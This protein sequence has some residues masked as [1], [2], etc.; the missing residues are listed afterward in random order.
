MKIFDSLAKTFSASK[1]P[2]VSAL[3]RAEI[4]AAKALE[5]AR[6]EVTRLQ[7]ALPAALVQGDAARQKARA[8]LRAAEDDAADAE[9]ALSIV[10]ERLTEARHEADQAARRTAYAAAQAV[11]DEAVVRL[12]SRYP[13]IVAELRGLIEATARADAEVEEAN[14]ALPAGAA[15]L[16]RVEDEVRDVPSLPRRVLAERQV[17]LWAPAGTARPAADQGGIRDEGGGRGR[18]VVVAHGGLSNVTQHF[19]LLSFTERKVAPG[20]NAAFA[21]RLHGLDLPALRADDAPAWSPLPPDSSPNAILAHL[22]ALAT[23]AGAPP[24]PEPERI[25]IEHEL[26]VP[27]AVAAE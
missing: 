8:E 26:I 14:S 16:A 21:P 18:R 24:A 27:P 11:R 7:A 2:S 17:A 6:N 13:A 10:R 23:E 1:A 25:D 4:E 22:D 3:E 9:T 12:R 20:R 15:P 19:D 5:G